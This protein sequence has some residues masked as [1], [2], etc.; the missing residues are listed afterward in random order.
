M[1]KVI[2][3]E[4]H[5]TKRWTKTF[6]IILAVLTAGLAYILWNVWVSV[7]MW[8]TLDMLTLFTQDQ[9]IV[10]EFWQDTLEV[11]WEELPQQAVTIAGI[12][13]LGIVLVIV[14]TK[15]RRMINARRSAEL[16]KKQQKGY[17]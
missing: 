5:R 1:E 3:F 17:K 12:V 7:S 10:R 6:W 14:M 2:R 11:F 9:E 8:G 15:R 4:E 13:A 16:A